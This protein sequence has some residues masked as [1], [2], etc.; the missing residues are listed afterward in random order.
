[1]QPAKLLYT[2]RETVP[3]NVCGNVWGNLVS[4][5]FE[6]EVINNVNLSKP[7]NLVGVQS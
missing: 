7:H 5:V 2:V 4:T 3:L 1:M 6:N